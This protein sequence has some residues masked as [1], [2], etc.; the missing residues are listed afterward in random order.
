MALSKTINGLSH[1]QVCSVQ[2]EYDNGNGHATICGWVD[3]ADK[4]AGNPAGAMYQLYFDSINNPFTGDPTKAEIET[5][6]LANESDF[7]GASQ[8]SDV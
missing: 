7:S 3:S 1:W 6:T 5:Y 4:I 2:H 8:V